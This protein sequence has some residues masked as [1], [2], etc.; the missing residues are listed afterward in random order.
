MSAQKKIVSLGDYL[1][2]KDEVEEIELSDCVILIR[3]R[4][5][6]TEDSMKFM[7][8]LGQS[9]TEEDIKRFQNTEVESQP[10]EKKIQML[11]LSY[12]QSAMLISSCCFHPTVKE[13][14][15]VAETQ[16]DNPRKVWESAENVMELPSELFEA[17]SE[18]V[19]SKKLIMSE[20][21]AKK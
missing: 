12:Q 11:K 17:L 15:T 6:S 10:I 13:D 4:R 3:I 21:E 2:K 9:M 16:E 8:L 14:G 7:E 20:I 5:P 18:R 19:G 1:K